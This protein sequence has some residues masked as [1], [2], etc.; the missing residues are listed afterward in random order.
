MIS[1]LEAQGYEARGATLSTTDSKDG[2]IE[3]DVNMIRSIVVPLIDKGRKVVLVLHSYAGFPGSVA[4]K[5]LSKSD[6]QAKGSDGGLIGIVYMC[7]FVPHEGVSLFDAIGGKWFEW[8]APN[9]S[10]VQHESL[11]TPAKALGDRKKMKCYGR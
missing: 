6:M 4:I 10:I 5:G 8:L 11:T 7:A 2:T 9:V 1:E 3:D